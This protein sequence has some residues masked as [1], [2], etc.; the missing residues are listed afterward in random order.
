M[1]DRLVVKI[2]DLPGGGCQC[3][4]A[5]PERARRQVGAVDALRVALERAYPGRTE[6]RYFD[7][8]QCWDESV[9]PAARLRTDGEA[10]S[11]VVLVDGH[12]CFSGGIPAGRIVR[13]VGRILGASSDSPG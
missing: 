9:E 12:V 1:S 10:P 7:L 11:P 6:V 5:S 2:V 4:A 3:S 13:E 8:S